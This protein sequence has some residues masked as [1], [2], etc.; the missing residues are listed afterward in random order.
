[1]LLPTDYEPVDPFWKKWSRSEVRFEQLFGQPLTGRTTVP[2]DIAGRP[3]SLEMA[4]C[5]A[6][7]TNDRLAIIN[8]AGGLEWTWLLA[9][10]SSS[11]TSP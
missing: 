2:T 4:G 6:S 1:M 7:N 11:A 10:V 3:G 9:L 8:E 5:K